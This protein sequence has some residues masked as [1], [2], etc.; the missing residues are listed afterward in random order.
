MD[1]SRAIANLPERFRPAYARILELQTQPRYVG[2]FIFGSLARGEATDA[3]D[4]DVK[5]ITDTD[6]TCSNINHPFVAGVKLDITFVSLRQQIEFTEQE[7][8]KGERVPMIA[9]SIIIFDQ[10]GELTALK[11]RVET[12]KR[13]P[14]A[15]DEYQHI[16]FMAYHTDNKV[17]RQMGVDSAAAVLSMGMGL[18]ELLHQHYKIRG[19]WVVSDKRLLHDLARW[20]APLVPLLR[21]FALAFDVQQKYAL[22][23]QIVDYV[24]APIGGRQPIAENNCDCDQCRVDLA[25]FAEPHRVLKN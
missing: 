15:P 6:S 22:W 24:L 16:Q 4:F 17:T 10:T 1:A 9:E 20:D 19:Q 7:I 11:R 2:A 13:Q 5:V 12:I 21:E 23:E 25:N 14:A 8:A 3:S 18:N